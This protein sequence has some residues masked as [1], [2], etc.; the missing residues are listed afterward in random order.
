MSKIAN[1]MDFYAEAV[2]DYHKNRK[3]NFEFGF[4]DGNIYP[5]DL[6]R[7]FRTLDQMQAIETKIIEMCSGKILD[8]GSSTG[9]Y[10][11]FMAK[12]GPVLGI[13]VAQKLVEFGNEHYSKDLVHGNIFTYDFDTQFDTIT[14]LENNLGICKSVEGLMKLIGIF[15]KILS[16]HGQILI[17]TKKYNKENYHYNFNNIATL[18]PY[19]NGNKGESFDWI[20]FDEDYLAKVFVENGFQTEQV[21]LNAD[22][23][24]LR[25][26]RV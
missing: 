14:L 23:L 9:Y 25:V 22:N 15:D 1:Q 7:Y 12:H 20:T 16:P 5:H 17:M 24:L 19:W 26:V 4:Q 6:S 2:I 8:I 18:T 13:E 21:F 10:L 11:P 3:P